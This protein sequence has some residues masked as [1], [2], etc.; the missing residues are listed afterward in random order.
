MKKF[1]CALLAVLM[2]VS[3][4]ACGGEEKPADPVSTPTE[5]AKPEAGAFTF[6]DN[7][8]EIALKADPSTL[9]ALGEPADK[10]E[11]A[12]CAFEGKD[13]TYF[14]GNFEVLVAQPAEGDSYI[15]SIVIKSDAVSTPE[16]LEIG[17]PQAKV[18]EIYG[19][20]NFDDPLYIFTKGE[21]QLRIKIADECVA[22][23]EY[24]IAAPAA[25]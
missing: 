14:Y 5:T 4:C 13:V 18:T 12:S 9:D 7:G 1:L 23:I 8:V 24:A 10:S 2:L 11:E 19:E 21:T 3:L 15:S 6:K 25:N 17:M 16:G 22:G 20:G